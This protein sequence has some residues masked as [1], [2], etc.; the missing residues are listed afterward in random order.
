M[1]FDVNK[2]ESC[3]SGLTNTSGCVSS[4]CRRQCPFSV[5]ASSVSTG[6]PVSGRVGVLSG[7]TCFRQSSGKHLVFT[8]RMV[9]SWNRF[10]I[11]IITG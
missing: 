2:Q 4:G 11:D 5:I 6:Q 1:S 9:F 7:K 8:G 3:H 10:I